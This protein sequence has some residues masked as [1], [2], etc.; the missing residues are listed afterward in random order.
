M[1]SINHNIVYNII[2][3]GFAKCL[4]L[5]THCYLTV[6]ISRN[7]GKTYSIMKLISKL[8]NTKNDSL[9]ALITSQTKQQIKN[10]II[11]YLHEY[12]ITIDKWTGS[13]TTTYKNI[14]NG[15][16][17]TF[18]GLADARNIQLNRGQHPNILYFDEGQEYNKPSTWQSIFGD[19]GKS[20]KCLKIISGTGGRSPNNVLTD[21]ENKIKNKTILGYSIKL[22]MQDVIQLDQGNSKIMRQN[23]LNETIKRYTK[24]DENGDVVQEAK[25]NP[26]FIREILVKD[27]EGNSEGDIKFSAYTKENKDTSDYI[28]DFSKPIFVSCDYG[29][30]DPYTA[31][32]SQPLNEN[33]FYVF[34]EM[35]INTKNRNMQ[36]FA[37]DL[38]HFMQDIG[39]IEYEEFEELSPTGTNEPVFRKNIKYLHKDI[40][41]FGDQHGGSNWNWYNTEFFGVT[42]NEVLDAK[43][44]VDIFEK[45]LYNNQIIINTNNCYQLDR[46]LKFARQEE[47]S[48]KNGYI[49]FDHSKS[50]LIVTLI[51]LSLYLI[52]YNFINLVSKPLLQKPNIEPMST[53]TKID[54]ETEKLKSLFKL[55]FNKK[56]NETLTKNP[57]F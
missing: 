55:N 6:R 52:D 28:I 56:P 36:T 39:I 15:S 32:F 29:S 21:I 9:K 34:N 38:A 47:E 24:I 53:N 37:T 11:P 23:Q 41:F 3:E 40:I 10:N 30:S 1:D 2:R 4:E 33:V 45:L 17:I 13:S 27:I 48:K 16:V 43:L 19:M 25:D 26:E 42:F 44:G 22:S 12:G 46:D 5:D 7:L 51:Y 18:G 31:T 35:Y 20:K 8:L 50:H 57:Y 14:E 54:Y 49:G